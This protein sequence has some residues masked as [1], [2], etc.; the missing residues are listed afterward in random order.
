MPEPVNVWELVAKIEAD[1]RQAD[2]N[3]DQ[4]ERKVQRLVIQYKVLDR[5]TKTVSG[6]HAK[7][8]SVLQGLD[9]PLSGISSRFSSLVGLGSKLSLTTS[10][11]GT[12]FGLGASGAVALG[13]GIFTLVK[14]TADAGDEIF[15][16]TQKVNFAAETISTL[17]N[18]GELAGVE[19]GNI[20]TSLGIFNK[21]VEAAHEGNEK[22]SN[23]FKVLKID[24]KDN[25]TALR[26]TFRAL[27]AVEDGGQQTA[28]AMQIFGKSGKEVLG[29]IKS[30]NGDVDAATEKFR[31]MGSLITTESAKAANDFSDK[32]KILEQRFDGVTRAIGERFMP[33]TIDAL[34]KV[35][36]A[37]DDNSR[38]AKTWADDLVSVTEFAATQVGHIL[39]GLAIVIEGF[40]KTFGEGSFFGDMAKGETQ[41]RL[42][43]LPNGKVID[44]NTRQVFDPSTEAG[45]RQLMGM[46]PLGSSDEEFAIAGG[47]GQFSVGAGPGG[48]V[49]R[50][51]RI[52]F[53]GG[54]GGGGSKK[55]DPAADIKRL[56]DLQ[57]QTTIETLRRE[58]QDIERS[59]DKRT[60]TVRVF[61]RASS[62][63]E[64]ERHK[65]TLDNLKAEREAIEK[66]PKLNQLQRSVALTEIEL[67]RVREMN[68]HREA[69]NAL[70]EKLNRATRERIVLT[71]TLIKLQT[72]S[73]FSSDVLMTTEDGL[74]VIMNEET[75]GATTRDRRVADRTRPRIATEAEQ[76]RRELFAEHMQ[77]VRDLASDIT[78]TIDDAIRTGFENG[79]GAGVR[80]F[81]LGILEMA[82]H[83]ALKR[84]EEAIAKALM[85]GDAL[86]SGSSSGGGGWFGKLLGIG[87]S[88]LGGLFGGVFSPHTGGFG[89]G[90]GAGGYLGVGMKAEG[91]F[92]KPYEWSWV[93]EKGPE[94]MRAGRDGA[95]VMSNQQSMSAM[96]KRPI[97]NN[98][99]ITTRDADSFNR[100][101]TQ[102]QI[103]RRMMKVQATR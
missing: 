74:G 103:K 53:G 81:G 43:S 93:G 56:A 28:L 70:A 33:I 98:W 3:I 84:L 64:D 78:F 90:P 37:L 94:L 44:L 30:L 2:R 18:E 4:N 36:R 75:R 6:S 57:L 69:E 88:S 13:A 40:R 31:K 48:I 101:E 22:L 82:R 15:D 11:L 100:R 1:F 50:G 45:K 52:N 102:A 24:I 76:R 96:N 29:V 80:A 8:G 5:E 87:I 71:E 73:R 99:Y 49:K 39:R 89:G 47:A 85:G 41:R 35:S 58:E 60:L 68:R 10:G 72:R 7:F 63:L 27:M 23:L 67:Q 59:F 86:A 20:S 9:G 26:S 42:L 61:Q 54:K 66:N 91:G 34:E 25:E 19:F 92:V 55:Y 16:L 95:T 97:V 38:H 14:R 65:A 77:R 83:A 12:A 21:N 79:I 17:K 62:R 51:G 32:L 46:P